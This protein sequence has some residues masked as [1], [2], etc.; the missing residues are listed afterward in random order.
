MFK[1]IEN[2]GAFECTNPNGKKTRRLDVS[3]GRDEE[4]R[5]V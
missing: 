2:E 5:N 3:G 4:G 1:W